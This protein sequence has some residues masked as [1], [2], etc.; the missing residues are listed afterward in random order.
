VI[1]AG[2]SQLGVD[3]TGILMEIRKRYGVE[4]WYERWRCSHV[5]R[6]E[7]TARACAERQ[8]RH[9][10]HPRLHTFRLRPRHG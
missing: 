3:F 1:K 4:C 5:H 9:A 2:I 7:R 6:N 10:P 8:L